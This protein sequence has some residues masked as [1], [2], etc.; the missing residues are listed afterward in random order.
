MEQNLAWVQAGIGQIKPQKP[1]RRYVVRYIFFIHKLRCV[2][3]FC[4]ALIFGGLLFFVSGAFAGSNSTDV[5]KKAADTTD[6]R[7]T[8]PSASQQKAI[9]QKAAIFNAG[10]IDLVNNGQVSASARLLKLMIGEPGKIS[11]PFS[12]YSGVSNN[13]FQQNSI[14]GYLKSNEHLLTQFITPLSG[15]LN[16]SVDGISFA[17]RHQRLTKFGLLYQ[18]GERVLT[19]VRTGSIA[20]PLT[21]KPY[22]FLN[23][24]AVGGLYL[25]T[26]AWERGREGNMGICW[27]TLRY[28][29]C[30][31]NPKQLHVFLSDLNTNGFY[32]G[33]SMG[34]GIEITSLVNI[35]AIY[36]RYDK[37]PEMDY[38]LPIYQFSFTYA[39]NGKY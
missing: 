12:V 17:G 18:A 2:Q 5:H 14:S 8:S 1:D 25:Q 13:A 21:G 15:L 22:N 10:F 38:G 28:H 34:F 4:V 7:T 37:A 35:K 24:Y 36:Y 33:F 27:L 39:L 26:G 11:I 9:S 3:N 23:S 20:N 16:F 6:I 31:S 32:T 29:C 19:G 30:Y